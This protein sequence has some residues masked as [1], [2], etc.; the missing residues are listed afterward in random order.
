MMSEMRCRKLE[1]RYI[2]GGP[3]ICSHF[4]NK[5]V[6]LKKRVF[7]YERIS[8]ATFMISLRTSKL[9]NQVEIDFWNTLYSIPELR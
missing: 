6:H 5:V 1:Y 7:A 2:Q 3:K 8:Y 4:F 9:K